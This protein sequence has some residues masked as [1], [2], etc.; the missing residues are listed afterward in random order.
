MKKV[1]LITAHHPDS[2]RKT[3]FHFWAEILAKDGIE[4]AWLTTGFSHLTHFSRQRKILPLPH[5]SW[6]KLS[7]KVFWYAWKPLFH[8]VNL[9]TGYLNAAS[10]VLFYFYRYLLPQK[11]LASIINADVCIV[12]NGS[13]LLLVEDIARANPKLKLIYTVS[14]RIRTLNYHPLI[15]AAEKNALPYF[16][17]I[18][19]PAAVM[20]NDYDRDLPV[21]YIPQGLHKELFATINQNPYSS[22]KNAISIGDML[23]DAASIEKLAAAYPDWNF[24]VFGR[25]AHLTKTFANVH[26]YGEVAFNKVIPFI[27]HADIALAPYSEADN[28]D[29]LS[30]SSLKM[31]QYTF[32]QL[33]IVAPDFASSGRAHVIPYT[34]GDDSIVNSFKTAQSIKRNEIPKDAVPDWKEVI[35]TMLKKADNNIKFEGPRY[36]EDLCSCGGQLY[37]DKNKIVCSLCGESYSK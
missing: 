6:T 14:D 33:P 36:I 13:G 32:C 19:V 37:I 3:G 15:L 8:P 35:Y 1:V 11:L 34:S 29:Y 22:E 21:E 5:N 4:V 23:F 17:L 16:N 7:D 26:E 28:A 2:E 31:Q 27:Q 9:R 25:R 30:Q 20:I 12:E 24:H 10:S 18:R